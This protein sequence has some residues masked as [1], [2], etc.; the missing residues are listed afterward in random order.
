MMWLARRLKRAPCPTILSASATSATSAMLLATCFPMRLP[1]V[2]GGLGVALL[3][4]ELLHSPIELMSAGLTNSRA[5]SPRIF[6]LFFSWFVGFR[7]FIIIYVLMIFFPLLLTDV[8]CR[9]HFP[10]YNETSNFNLPA[11]STLL[12][13]LLRTMGISVSSWDSMKTRSICMILGI[14]RK[15]PRQITRHP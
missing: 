1:R 9:P 13:R 11:F 6:L 10:L 8:G 5:S 4:L 15:F 7:I 14:D 3:G 12:T 2:V